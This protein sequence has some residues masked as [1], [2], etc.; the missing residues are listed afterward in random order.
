MHTFFGILFL[1]SA[2]KNVDF[3][4][5]LYY[6]IKDKLYKLKGLI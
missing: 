6:N 2:R 4:H 5:S 3:L 1:R